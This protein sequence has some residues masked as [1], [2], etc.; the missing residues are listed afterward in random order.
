MHRIAAKWFCVLYLIQGDR[1]ALDSIQ[2]F[3]L[4]K[5]IKI[6]G[7]LPCRGELSLGELAWSGHCI[8]AFFPSAYYT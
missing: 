8:S 7:G 4:P 5:D 2:E 6:A 3:H 1:S